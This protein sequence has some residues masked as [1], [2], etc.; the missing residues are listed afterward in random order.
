LLIITLRGIFTLVNHR[1]RLAALSICRGLDATLKIVQ[2]PK[3]LSYW[4]ARNGSIVQHLRFRFSTNPMHLLS[5]L[6][7][8]TPQLRSLRAAGLCY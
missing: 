3:L 1:W 5:T 4:L 7:T 8:S 6:P 2:S